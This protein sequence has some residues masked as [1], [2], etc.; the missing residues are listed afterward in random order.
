MAAQFAQPARACFQDD[1][2]EDL[3]IQ[4]LGGNKSD[5]GASGR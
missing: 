4:I 3:D 2:T 1:F 5:V